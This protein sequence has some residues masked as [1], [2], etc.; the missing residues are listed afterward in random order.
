MGRNTAVLHLLPHGGG[1]VGAVLRALLEA[2]LRESTSIIPSIASL[3]RL[4]ET[5]R[6]HFKALG[7]SWIDCVA[8]KSGFE[9]LSALVRR[10]DIVLVH[11][12][13]HPLLMR[14]LFQGLP[15]SRL[16]LWSHV[17]GFAAPQ[18]FFPE[19]FDFPDRF[20]FATKASWQSPAVHGLPSKIMNK[21]RVIRSCAGI[22][23]N[24]IKPCIK[25]GPFQF[26]YVGTVE[27]AKMHPDFLELCAAAKIPSR[28]IV[29]GGP[30]HDELRSQADH[31][32]LG[33]Q[34]DI[35]GPVD[36]PMPYFRRLH[37]FAYPLN[38]AHYGSGEQVLVEAMAYGAVPVVFDN[39]PEKALI[40]HGETGLI[41]HS[42]EEFTNALRFLADNPAD[43]KRLAAAGRQF[44][45]DEC[46]IKFS[47]SDFHALYDEMLSLPK[48]PHGLGLPSF[49]GIDDGSPFHLF[50][51]SCGSDATRN[52]FK[53][54]GVQSGICSPPTGFS[55]ITRGTPQHYL[56][57]LGHDPSLERICNRYYRE[58]GAAP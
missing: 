20:V 15:P 11:W 54:I 8:M 13:N 55:S 16:A 14:L 7:I 58:I 18:S 51:A 37:A 39:P 48:R 28:C 23:A 29:A 31:L 10:A 2:E 41:T 32:G 43:R 34:F 33:N 27:P 52:Y 3:E 30:A 56:R 1:G 45:F 36:D 42:A 50:L 44:V 57:L 46:D 47:V 40:R 38:S 49:D 12:W 24:A 4:N 35:L 17:N 22:P 26:G 25:N 6:D 21:L 5:T 19:L 53:K 9:K